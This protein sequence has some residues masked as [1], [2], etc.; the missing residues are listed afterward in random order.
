MNVPMFGFNL[1]FFSYF[2]LVGSHWFTDVYVYDWRMSVALLLLIGSHSFIVF[3][4]VIFFSLVPLYC[5]RGAFL[6]VRL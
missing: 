1:I 2:I 3:F 4:F 5:V 6:S